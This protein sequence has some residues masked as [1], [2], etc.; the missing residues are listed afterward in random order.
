MK[1]PR[2]TKLNPSQNEIGFLPPPS[3]LNL[4]QTLILAI[5]LFAPSA[6]QAHPGHH[7]FESRAELIAELQALNPHLSPADLDRKLV[8]SETPFQFFRAFVP[9]YYSEMKKMVRQSSLAAFAPVMNDRGFCVG[10]AHLENFGTVI[11][12]Q[13]GALFTLTDLDDSGPCPLYMD[14]LRFF[15]SALMNDSDADVSALVRAYQEGLNSPS[16]ETQTG[17]TTPF[18]YSKPVKALLAKARKGGAVPPKAVDF[19][20]PDAPVLKRPKAE[21]KFEELTAE[22]NQNIRRALES[23]YSI[24]GHA[25]LRD[26]Y[27]TRKVGGG[28][29]G[30]LRY[31]TVV[32]FEAKDLGFQ[33][34]EFKQ[35]V[36]PGILPVYSVDPR[37]AISPGKESFPSAV[38]RINQA[39]LIEQ[40]P[41]PSPL[42]QVKTVGGVEMLLRPKW[43]GN[44]SVDLG[45]YSKKEVA[46]IAVDE[47]KVLGLLHARSAGDLYAKEIA[48][49]DES[50]WIAAAQQVANKMRQAHHLLREQSSAEKA[51]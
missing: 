39:L 25:T 30:L 7:A 24:A 1:T 6:S 13:G 19:S 48:Q 4:R 37:E 35:L 27:E 49:I 17:E 44:S 5:L 16:P 46:E 8:A 34:I 36:S 9:F 20:N 43:K 32:E 42:Y 47:A 26:G 3:Q 28:S 14:A 23:A 10:D 41:F 50:A 38:E 29:H 12:A 33:M 40:G 11:D 15:T 31:E 2:S 18:R 51:P 22:K 45:D 21:E